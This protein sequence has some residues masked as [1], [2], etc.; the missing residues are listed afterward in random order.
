[1]VLIN[2]SAELAT[3]DLSVGDVSILTRPTSLRVAGRLGNLALVNN[4]SAYQIR[5]EFNQLLSIEGE[6]F[7]DFTYSTFDPSDDSYTGIASM[8]NLNTASLK[9]NYLEQPLRDLYVFLTRLAHLKYIYD[10]ARVAAAQTAPDMNRMQFSVSIK[11]P[12]LVFPH[13]PVHRSDI[14]IMRLGHIEA[15]NAF[16]ATANKMTA[17]L[18]GIKL[19]S[20]LHSGGEVANLK[21]I[22]DINVDANITQTTGID[23]TANTTYPDTKVTSAMLCEGLLLTTRQISVKLSDIKL[24]LT[25]AQYCT[26]MQL[27][28]SIP[29]VFDNGNQSPPNDLSIP[30]ADAFKEPP[31]SAVSLQPELRTND[32]APNG[33]RVWTSLDLVLSVGAVKLHLYDASAMSEGHLKDHGIARFALNDNSLRLKQLSDGSMEAQVILRSFTMS[34]T[35]PGQTKFREIIPAAQHERNQFMI[36]YTSSGAQAVGG[37]SSLAVITVDSPQVIFA[38]DPVFALLSFFT[39]A[40]PPSNTQS[41]PTSPANPSSNLLVTPE[42]QQASQF[43]FRLDLHDVSISI[44]EDETD[45]QSRA[46]RLH[47]SQLLLSQQVRSSLCVDPLKLNTSTAGYHSSH[48]YATGNVASAYGSLLRG[49]AVPGQLGPHCFVRQP[50]NISAPNE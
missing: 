31:P 17:S 18:H 1:M 20:S 41:S 16:E 15:N 40:F 48:Y 45:A 3:L 32:Q 38:V 13:D 26:L 46:M 49:G 11:S 19:V 50:G 7:A 47:I 43:D 24:H 35:R 36:L 22:D 4:N 29:R 23:R 42:E 8:I 12:I 30:S 44:L 39:S 9:F 34:N 14:F 10:A 27:A 28:R 5:P 21:I 6:N 2:E 37:A 33:V 25:Q